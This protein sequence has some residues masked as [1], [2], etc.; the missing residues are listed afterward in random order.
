MIKRP[1]YL[2]DLISFRDKDLIKV[3]SGVRR[4]GKSTLLELFQEYLLGNGVDQSQIIS[5]NLEEGDYSHITETKQLYDLVNNQLSKDKMNYVFLDE[6]QRVF[7]FEKACDSLYVKRNVDLYITGSNAYILSGELATYLSGRYIEIKMMPLSF[8]EYISAVGDDKLDQKYRNY[9]LNSSFPYVLELKTKKERNIYLEGIFNSII[10][11][12]IVKRKPTIDIP[13]LQSLVKFMFDNIGNISSSTNIANAM[14]SAG[15][16]ISVPTV[17][18]YLELL[19]GSFILYK[20]ERFDIKGKQYLA[21]GYKYYVCD[22]GLRYYLLGEKKVDRGYILENIVYLELIRRGYE[23][24]VGKIGTTEVDFIAIDENSNEN[25]YQVAYKVEDEEDKKILER[26]LKPLNNIN[27]HN[28][29]YLLTMDDNP[30][31]S[32]NGIKQIYVLDWLLDK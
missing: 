28:P 7:E 6:V 18:S 1:E 24:S 32:H 17:E 15:R 31:I 19:L 12:D 11:K 29:K 4:C 30:I 25:Y 13:M 14:T 2:K 27:D 8:K 22:I 9:T 26:E 5:I 16:K 21:S 20:A 3:V 10:I 23:V